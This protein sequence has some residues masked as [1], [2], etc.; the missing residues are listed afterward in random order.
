MA[1]GMSSLPPESC[2]SSTLGSCRACCR[3]GM[4]WK[5]GKSPGVRDLRAGFEDG[6][7]KF[8]VQWLVEEPTEVLAAEAKRGNSRFF[9]D[10]TAKNQR[11]REGGCWFSF[12]QLISLTTGPSV[13]SLCRSRLRMPARSPLPASRTSAT[14]KATGA[15]ASRTAT[16]PSASAKMYVPPSRTTS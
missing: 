8:S 1:R 6:E 14:A 13:P 3:V 15:P 7:P 12:H 11:K 16:A 4:P 10:G 5:E 9:A 2:P